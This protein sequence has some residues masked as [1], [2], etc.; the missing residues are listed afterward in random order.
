MK[1]E[2]II[3]LLERIKKHKLELQSIKFILKQDEQILDKLV[4]L[5]E[6]LF[7]KGINLVNI[8]T[9]DTIL[10][11]LDILNNSKYSYTYE[12]LINDNLIKRGI[13]LTF[14]RIINSLGVVSSSEYLK[15]ILCN[16]TDIPTDMLFICT[17]M[18][19]NTKYYFNAKY[20]S[21]VLCSGITLSDEM[22]PLL[23]EI[24]TTDK[25]Y[26]ARYISDIL[27]YSTLD[28]DTV[29]LGIYEIVNNSREEYTSR[30]ISRLLCH[31]NNID[32][33]IIKEG[34]KLINNTTSNYMAESLCEVL[35]NSYNIPNDLV[36]DKARILIEQ[37]NNY[38]V[39]IMKDDIIRFFDIERYSND[40]GINTL[41]NIVNEESNSD[42]NVKALSKKLIKE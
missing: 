20:V 39:R 31:S 10:E 15:C 14:G 28:L 17:E 4:N 23:K 3:I 38:L 40:N 42:I 24:A 25:I 7:T 2:K 35:I 21:E 13:S 27:I 36:L 9:R 11:A 30:C 26:C 19:K 1:R 6:E 5:K 18:I 32:K 12:V 41:I 16:R 37:K 22:L 33:E 8:Y 34:I 29:S